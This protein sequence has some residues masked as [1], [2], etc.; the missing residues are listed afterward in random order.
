MFI[1]KLIKHEREM[2]MLSENCRDVFGEVT[3]FYVVK[4]KRFDSKLT[5]DLYIQ[6]LK[7]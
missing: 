3:P 7:D 4:F 6:R 5:L 2:I 1:L